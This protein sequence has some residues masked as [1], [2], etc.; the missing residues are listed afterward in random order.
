M[1]NIQKGLEG[2]GIED[3]KRSSST[4]MVGVGPA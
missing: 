4:Q 2:N 1:R 3:R